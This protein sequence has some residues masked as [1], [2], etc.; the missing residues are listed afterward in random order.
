MKNGGNYRFTKGAE[1][2][3]HQ[4]NVFGQTLEGDKGTDRQITWGERK[5]SQH[6]Q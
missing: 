3:L 6:V 5:L 1:A 4:A 2:R